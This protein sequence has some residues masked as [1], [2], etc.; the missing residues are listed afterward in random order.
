MDDP[1][2]RRWLLSHRARRGLLGAL[3]LLL[4]PA[5][6]ELQRG[7]ARTSPLVVTL[8]AEE[9]ASVLRALRT[10]VPEELAS[11]LE[12]PT[13]ATEW[14]EWARRHD[15]RI[16]A[17]LVRGEEDSLVNFLLFGTSFTRRPRVTAKDVEALAHR[18]MTEQELFERVGQLLRGRL[19][20]LLR[21]LAAPGR[22]ERLLFLQQLLR[23]EGYDPRAA[24]DRPRLRAHVLLLLA[25]A[26]QEQ[27]AL[28][29][30]AQE[31]ERMAT[32]AEEFL[33]RS[34]LYRTRGLSLDTSLWPNFALEEALRA[35]HAR[36]HLPARS[37]RTVAII[38]PG[39]DFTDK[40]E[41]FDFYP[42]QTLQ[43]FAL[44]DMLR[45]LELADA[46]AL[47]VYALDLSERVIQHL[48]RARQRA[49]RGLGYTMHLALDPDIPWRPEALSFWERF[50]MAIGTPTT[51]ARVPPELASLRRRAIRVR[52]DVVRSVIPVN[53]N[54]VLQ[55]VELPARQR[56]DLII[57]TNVFVYYDTVAQSLAMKNIEQMLRPGGFLLSNNALPE[58]PVTRLRS[59]GY[60]TTVYSDRPKDGDHIVWYQRPADDR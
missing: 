14:A 54:I 31:A 56:F 48:L 25:R 53:A 24:T 51:P 21:A 57:A 50:G 28:A 42:I 44:V 4:P 22:N 58:L 3:L 49:H 6:V 59:I 60:S 36:G 46:S 11:A 38:G 13:F 40:Q 37:V 35:L 1:G 15:A 27:R 17:R 47:R 16:R 9:A 41:G 18:A 20:D 19:E 55:R 39:L 26:L 12:R 7:R 8:S 32:P 52:P 2:T 29:H 33:L 5:S 23:R 10:D 34:T 30:A 43:P 45:R